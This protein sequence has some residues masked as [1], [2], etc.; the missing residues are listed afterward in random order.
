M[1]FTFEVKIVI[2]FF[3]IFI[4]DRINIFSTVFYIIFFH[5]PH[6]S[7]LKAGRMMF[8]ILVTMERRNMKIVA[9]V[10][11]YLGI[12]VLIWLNKIRIYLKWEKR[13]KDVL[14]PFYR[15]PAEVH[16]EPD[17]KEEIRKAKELTSVVN[18]QDKERGYAQ[19]SFSG[20]TETFWC[21][22]AMCQCAKYK[23]THKPC[24]HI[25]KIALDKGLI[26]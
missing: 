17:Q 24:K 8:I 15:W 22:L 1:Y 21:N 18:Y 23:N 13:K 11:W 4:V 7:L 10:L 16:Q 19:T 3:H 25:Y 2:Y 20:E 12:L 26:E 5:S 9:I 14:K 6:L